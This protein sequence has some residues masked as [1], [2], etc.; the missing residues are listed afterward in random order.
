MVIEKKFFSSVKIYAGAPAGHFDLSRKWFVFLIDENGNR[1]RKFSSINQHNTYEGRM[2]AAEA[3][4]LKWLE[5]LHY[6][7][8]AK[9]LLAKHVENRYYKKKKTRNGHI[10]K[11]K[12]FLDWIGHKKLNKE[13]SE[14]FFDWLKKNR[15]GTTHND[16][17][18][19]LRK[20]LREVE[21]DHLLSDVKK[22]K[23]YST[24]ARYFQPHQQRTLINHMKEH[25]EELLLHVRFIYYCFIRNETELLPLKVGDILFDERKILIKGDVAKNGKQEYVTIPDA[26]FPH[27]KPLLHKS[28][29]EYIFPSPIYPGRHVS[30]NV[31]RNRHRKILKLYNFD[32]SE[33]QLYSWKHTGAVSAI[34]AGASV[35][36]L[37]VQMRHH[38]LEQVDDYL[39]Q[40]GAHD[41][42]NFRR[43]MPEIGGRRRTDRI[44]RELKEIKEKLFFK[45]DSEEARIAFLQRVKAAI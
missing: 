1:Q 39:R 26:F 8:R 44:E 6:T 45:E 21:M 18:V 19:V 15:H 9:Q 20:L 30:K 10:S 25:D 43:V 3:V 32:T 29:N 35:K 42:I 14:L 24:P 17:I 27:L 11:V 5:K 22:I 28:P 33:Y 16:Y 7:F 2:K 41:L 40:I 12:C 31:L 36:E 4:R 38:S 37:Q 13:N 34:L 23:A